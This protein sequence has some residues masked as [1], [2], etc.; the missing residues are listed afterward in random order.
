[1]GASFLPPILLSYG[2]QSYT[3]LHNWPRLLLNFRRVLDLVLS[4]DYQSTEEGTQSW[5]L[6][7]FLRLNHGTIEQEMMM[8]NFITAAMY[9]AFLKETRFAPSTFPDLPEQLNAAVI[10]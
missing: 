5:C 7:K 6:L 8:S 9:L 1:M 2:K 4:R 3:K 10:Q